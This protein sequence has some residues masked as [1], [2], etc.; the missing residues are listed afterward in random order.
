M[1]QFV[2]SLLT[3]IAAASA[4]PADPVIRK[5]DDGLRY[6][7]AEGPD[8]TPQLVDLWL[9]S[10]DLAKS[11][12]YNPDTDNVYHLFTRLNSQRS[13]IIP[14]GDD[15]LLGR[16]NFDP[17]K[18]III[19]V[20][21]W[22]DNVVSDL[23]TVLV[24]AFLEAVDAN[25]FVVDWY[26]G[27]GLTNYAT[28]LSNMPLSGA[29]IARFITWLTRASG[30]GLSR[31]HLV[32][33]GVGGHL[34]GVVGRNL[35]G[36][37]PYITSLDPALAGFITNDDKFDAD[38]GIYTEVIHTNAGLLGY[39]APL[40]KT[41]FYPNGGID[42]PGCM[43]QMCDHHRSFHFMAES[44]RR[45]G[46]RGARCSTFITAMAG[47]CFLPGNLNMGGI[48]PKTGQVGIYHLTTRPFPPFSRS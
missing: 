5:L 33:H 39:I 38:D 17:S 29:G 35:G 20:H 34:V 22:L 8:G 31:Y 2:G 23:N 27:G 44:V 21:G 37:V 12:R 42:M 6:Q 45:G 15:A 47:N 30:A 11:A 28:V 13:Q 14:M 25:V 9:K 19:L 10:S 16:S 26:A 32:G 43:S 4:L 48:D 46:F 7:Y 36:R 3:V 1:M 41:D 40:G 18:R 24:P